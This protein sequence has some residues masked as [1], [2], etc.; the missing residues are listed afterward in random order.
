M[1]KVETWP[2]PLKHYKQTSVL[3]IVGS[4]KE[5]TLKSSVLNSRSHNLYRYV[6]KERDEETGLYYYGARYHCGWLC[7]FISVDP[8]KDKFP[9][10]STY[11]YAGNRPINAID[12]DGA[13]SLEMDGEPKG[14][15]KEIVQDNTNLVGQSDQVQSTI[16]RDQFIGEHTGNVCTIKVIHETAKGNEVYYEGSNADAPVEIQMQ[17]AYLSRELKGENASIIFTVVGPSTETRG[18]LMQE[19]AILS[20]INFQYNYDQGGERYS[21]SGAFTKQAGSVHHAGLV[22]AALYYG[23]FRLFGPIS[24]LPSKTTKPQPQ[25]NQSVQKI[26]NLGDDGI[27]SYKFLNNVDP[28]KQI[29]GKSASSKVLGQNLEAAEVTRPANSAAHHMVAG[30]DKRAAVSRQI[31]KRA[32]ID[33]NAAENGVFLPKSSAHAVPPAI[34][35]SRIHTNVYYETLNTRLSATTDVLQEL[36]LIRQEILSGGFP[37]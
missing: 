27:Q 10:Y 3:K 1:S 4:E 15:Q 37:Y 2:D 31:L 17:A 28:K 21:A 13:E 5:L 23:L 14:Q 16:K 19:T 22:D 6:H 20:N 24:K 30:S 35:H 29:L 12:L 7:R 18:G 34:T 11:Q 8:L 36:K 26:A 9:F 25:N 32:G 33:I